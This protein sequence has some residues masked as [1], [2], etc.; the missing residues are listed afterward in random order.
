MAVARSACKVDT[1][2]FVAQ[3]TAN[4]LLENLQSSQSGQHRIFRGVVVLAA[5]SMAIREERERVVFSSR[6]EGL[7]DHTYLKDAATVVAAPSAAVAVVAVPGALAAAPV[8]AAVA[9]VAAT[10]VAATVAFAP[11]AAAAGAVA[12]A[13]AVP[14]AAAVRSLFEAGP[15]PPGHPPHSRSHQPP[16]RTGSSSKRC[17]TA[18]CGRRGPAGRGTPANTDRTGT[19]APHGGPVCAGTAYSVRRMP[20]DS[21]GS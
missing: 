6:P 3:I 16:P 7:K 19:A 10:A 8:A 4:S 12:A 9:V 18:G 2:L 13:T 14:D 5:T 17:G 20:A 1:I 21:A 15:P 11:R